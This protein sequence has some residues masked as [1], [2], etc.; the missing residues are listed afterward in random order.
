M[1]A[2]AN[3]G[4]TVDVVDT[5]TGKLGHPITVGTLPSAVA[6]LPGAKDLLVTVKAQDQ[7]VEVSTSTGKV[8]HRI[9]VGL[10]PDAVAVTPDGTLALV[11][12]FGD[13]TVT[14]VHLGSFT[15]GADRP[16]RAPAGGHRHLPGRDPGARRRLRGRDADPD[17]AFPA[18]SAGAPVPVG[19]EPSAVFIASDGTT[20]LVADF[21]TSSV[22]ASRC[23]RWSPGR[24]VPI[25]ANPTGIAAAPGSPIAWVSAG[26]GITPVDIATLQVG[27]PISIGTPSECMAIAPGGHPWVCNGDGALV[28][29]NPTTAG[30]PVRT[31][32]LDGVVPAAVAISGGRRDRFESPS[33][34]RPA[35]GR[36]GTG[37]CRRRRTP[38]P[39]RAGWRGV[40]GRHMQQRQLAAGPDPGGHHPDQ[41]LAQPL[42]SMVRVGGHR[43]DLGPPGRA[44]PLAG[45]GDQP[46][47]APDP[48]VATELPGGR[49]EGPGPG[50]RH[51][52]EHVG[53]S[54]ASE[55]TT[56]ASSAA[57]S[58]SSVDHA[59]PHR[60]SAHPHR[61]TR[62]PT[63]PAAD[64]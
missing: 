30:S 19:P 39:R 16:R 8:V 51:Q 50:Q 11:A 41:E 13:N 32:N 54:S 12:N 64:R 36:P 34:G 4:D 2:F 40:V 56:S 55:R 53:H 9:G 62:P 29:V 10:E 45:H 25:G 1:S 47:A 21:E 23:R 31:V 27:N 37:P 58:S 35:P 6:L 59:A 48:D 49:C 63:P 52:L 24:T 28:E 17:L 57:T 42:A 46:A 7:L 26:D 15:A 18:L 44:H 5:V 33:D 3:P 60:S 61:R 43:A 14:P 20:A 38:S 22:T